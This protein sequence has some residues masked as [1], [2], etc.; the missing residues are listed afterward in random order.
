M[1]RQ[2]VKKKSRNNRTKIL[3]ALLLLIAFLAAGVTVWILFFRDTGPELTPDYAPRQAEEYA[4]LIGGDSGEKMEVPKGGGGVSMI[5][6]KTVQIS[7]SDN[8][9]S[10]MFQNPSKSVND[11]VLQIVLV[12]DDKTETVIAQSGTL[13]PGYKLEKLDLLKDAAKLSAGQ[14][15]GRY[16]V[17][18]YD[19]ETAERSVLNGS[20]EGVEITVTE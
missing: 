16:N 15:T 7:L 13:S 12:G 17:L 19:P 20:I 14:Y 4:E 6:Q 10:L 9:A 5:Y 3:T 2:S 8:T 18:Y 1:G 11:I